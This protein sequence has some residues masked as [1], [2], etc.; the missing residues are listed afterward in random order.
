M[1][2][3]PPDQGSEPPEPT[4]LTDKEQGK[5]QERPRGSEKSS[6]STLE[7]GTTEWWL[8]REDRP[9]DLLPDQTPSAK[10]PIASRRGPY[11]GAESC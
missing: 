5:D 3:R 11:G 2:R 1:K 9:G 8:E 6:P 10:W 7:P 4:W